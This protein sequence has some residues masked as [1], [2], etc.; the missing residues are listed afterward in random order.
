MKKSRK[1]G[2]PVGAGEVADKRERLLNAAASLVAE[3]GVEAVSLR[4]IAAKAGVTPAMINYYF[5]DKQGL[6][7]AVLERG[8]EKLF[9]V[10]EEVAAR[11]DKP[12]AEEFIAR[13]VQVLNNDPS[14]PQL[15]VRE[16]LSG[17]E[18]Y[19]TKLREHFFKKVIA[20]L[21]KRLLHDIELGRIRDD[22]DPRLL[23][24]SLIGMCVFPFIAKPMIGPLMNLAFDDAFAEQLIN[25]TRTLFIEGARVEEQA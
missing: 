16:V 20:I 3:K 21:P 14:L 1:P 5:D 15:L 24:L 19:R 9:K 11:E 8:L 7:H 18:A 25:H 6:M 23:L 2:R 22:Y 12:I 13:Y 4:E 10:V 17:N